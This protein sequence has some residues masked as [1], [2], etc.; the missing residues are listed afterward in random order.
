ME[1]FKNKTIS[2]DIALVGLKAPFKTPGNLHNRTHNCSLA[3][4]TRFTAG[5][6]PERG[7]FVINTMRLTAETLSHRPPSVFYV[8]L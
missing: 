2:F 8:L 3:H 4:Q 6:D 5:V 1:D 7:D